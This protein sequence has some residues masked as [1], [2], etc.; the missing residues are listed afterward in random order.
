MPIFLLKRTLLAIPTLFLVVVAVFA[1]A[2]AVPTATPGVGEGEERPSDAAAERAFRREFGLDLPV[3]LNLR[4]RITAADV[5]AALGSADEP[6]WRRAQRDLVDAG[7]FAVAPLADVASSLSV[8][9][10]VRARAL[11]LLPACA[12]GPGPGAG[13]AE[14]QRWAAARPDPAPTLAAKLEIALTET[15]FAR[16]LSR[17]AHLDLGRA[18]S[19]RQPV[20]P[21]LL[22]RLEVTALLGCLS[23]LV[24]YGLAIPLGC[25][26]AYLFGWGGPRGRRV[27]R[28]ASLALFALYSLPIF[29]TATLLLRCLTVGEPLRWFPVGALED[30]DAGGRGAFAHA[31]DV[32]HHLVLPIVCLSYASVAVL[33]RYL[34][35]SLLEVIGSDCVRTA[36]AKGL[37]RGESLRRHALRPALLPLATL[38]GQTLPAIVS[39]SVIV[40][41]LF[42]LPGI[43]TYLLEAIL[44]RDYNAILAVTLLSAVVT[45]LGYVISDVLLAWLDPRIRL[46]REPAR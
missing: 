25:L 38:F 11:K 22:R 36:R 3:F 6:T 4:F 32:A 33:A 39:G 34:R 42:D 5:A 15:R 45:L 9:D 37:S 35:A 40:E 26:L 8:P 30:R 28:L 14:W 2:N 10:E 13:A 23:L 7:A 46:E 24:A 27:E 29:F 19:D 21:T 16:Y 43:G 17:L 12:D 31:L 18:L 44:A 1:F 20:L 41:Y